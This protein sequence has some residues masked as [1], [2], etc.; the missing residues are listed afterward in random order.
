MC[1]PTPKNELTKA[2]M[3]VELVPVE[4]QTSLALKEATSLKYDDLMVM[5]GM[6]A[7]AAATLT[8]M[9]SEKIPQTNLLEMPQRLFAPYDANGNPLKKL[10]YPFKNGFGRTG[11]F[12][13]KLGNIR[14]TRWVEIS[15]SP[16]T[17]QNTPFISQEML[18]MVGIT[19]IMKGIEQKI[20][21]IQ[22]TQQEILD[23]LKDDKRASLKANIDFLMDILTNYQSNYD[24]D[25]YKTNMHIKVLDI[26]Q[27]AEQNIEFYRTQISKHI[28]KRGQI[29]SDRKAKDK[30]L[31]I[32]SDLEDYRTALN[33]FSFASYVE[34][35]LL[36]N[37]QPD[38]LDS[39]SSK[40]RKYSLQYRELYS[41]CY[42]RIKDYISTSVNSK[43]VK[44]VAAASKF[45]GK[46]IAK[47]PVVSRGQLDENLIEAHSKLNKWNDDRPAKFLERLTS[48][49]DL[50]T[51]VFAER[52]DLIN[53]LYNQPKQVYFDAKAIY[54]LPG[55]CV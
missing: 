12:H 36:E 5:G 18:A 17:P 3:N 7:L 13:D 38:Y 31:Q 28:E 30:L 50:S 41:E 51:S 42:T 40:I 20:D 26:R 22:E 43:A 19:L 39:V 4:V 21:K 47:I 35:L 55:P 45:A 24:N 49:K 37:Y 10:P 16:I 15:G 8:S 27:S 9:I 54:L 53:Q 23:F 48:C 14:Q 11:T 46:A 2:F 44:G 1:E 32:Q 33:L 25:M 52:I 34:V 6:F 29:M